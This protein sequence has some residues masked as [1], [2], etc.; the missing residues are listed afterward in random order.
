MFNFKEILFFVVVLVSN[1][2]QCVTGFAGTV[3][4]MPF[5]IMLVGYN[6]AKPI[7]NL[8]GIVVSNGVVTINYKALNKKEFIR[9]IS[10]MLC[11][12]VGGFLITR[13]F[14]VSPA[15]LYKLLGVIVIGFM[16]LGCYHSFSKK[17]KEKQER[18]QKENKPKTSV[19]SLAVL[20]IAGIVHGM[21]S[22]GGPLMVVYASEHL[23]GRDEFRVTVSATWCVLNSII[24]FTD[25]RAGH[26]NPHT[27]VLTGVSI[28]LLFLALFIGNLIFRHM[29]KRW[30]MII[31]Y[32]LMGISGV[33]LLIK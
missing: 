25:I 9:I 15:I 8:L 31:T 7:L 10:I 4:A 21:F 14:D 17:Y 16:G 20:V 5:S 30:F 22:C 3:L 32:V 33:S 2:I 11:G 1:I 6:T 24:L 13:S 28:G 27:M 12:M 29:N 23:K 26:F 19:W 18:A